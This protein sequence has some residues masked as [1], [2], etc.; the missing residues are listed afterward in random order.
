MS[1]RWQHCLDHADHIQKPA[2]APDCLLGVVTQPI[3]SRL[4]ETTRIIII[5]MDDSSYVL[6][7][8]ITFTYTY[9]STL[10]R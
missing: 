4:S 5:A 3:D 10:K 8:V 6:C 9:T 2:K 7:G 1:A